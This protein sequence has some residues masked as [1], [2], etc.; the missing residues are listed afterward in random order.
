MNH[1]TTYTRLFWVFLFVLGNL[2]V[3]S[4]LGNYG[5]IQAAHL[6]GNG[7][8]PALESFWLSGDQDLVLSDTLPGAPDPR[9]IYFNNAQA[10]TLTLTFEISGTAP[11]TLSAGAVFGYTPTLRITDTV[12]ALTWQ[13]VITYSVPA[14][15]T[16]ETGVHYTITN[17]NALTTTLWL[18]YIQDIAPPTVTLNLPSVLTTAHQP[19]FALTGEAGDTGVG[20][21]QIEVQTEDAG[22]WDV[23]QGTPTWL[24]TWTLPNAD[25]FAYTPTARA[26]DHLGNQRRV[27]QTVIVDT[28]V[29]TVT[30]PIPHR[31]PWTTQTVIYHWDAAQDGAGIAGYRVNITNTQGYTDGFAVV[32]DTTTLTFTNA[33]MEGA[34]YYARVQAIDNH[35]NVGAWSET[36]SSVQP[37]LS[38]PIISNPSIYAPSEYFYVSGLTLFYTNTMPAADIFT[39]K[40]N[41]TDAPSGLDKATFSAALGQTPPMDASPSAFAGNYDVSPGDTDSGVI[42]ATLYDQAGQTSVQIFTYTLDSDPPASVAVAPSAAG[43]TPIHVTWNAIDT[44]SGVYSTTL[45]YKK[46]T[47]TAWTAY[48][49]QLTD[50]GT[51][52]FTPPAGDGTYYFS[53]VAT[54]HLGN[55]EGGRTISEAQT[56]FDTSAPQAKVSSVPDYAN[57][58]PIAVS[59]IA[60]PT[61]STLKEVRLWYRYDGGDWISTTLT[62]KEETGTFQFVGTEDGGYDFA[63]VAIDK[64]ERS[65]GEPSGDDGVEGTTFYDTVAPTVTVVVP[66]QAART[67]ISVAWEADDPAPASGVLSYQVAYQEDGGEWKTWYE[68]TTLTTANFISVATTLGHT[69][70]FSVTAQDAAGNAGEGQGTVRYEKFQVFIPL[71]SRN[72]AA[73]YQRDLNEP[74]DTR[75]QAEAQ[76][77]L[78]YGT[79]EAYIWQED[80]NDYYV[81]QP[82]D[83]GRI[84]VQLDYIPSGADYDLYIYD[85][86]TGSDYVTRSANYGNASEE[87]E[88]DATNGTKYYIRVY[89]YQGYNNDVL[90]KLTIHDDSN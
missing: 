23:A 57:T 36:G 77:N 71:T 19:D 3:L 38:P 88:F 66:T 83:S 16:T 84:R 13:P 25:H 65:D 89:P 40:G 44:L 30:A 76:D 34:E 20:V 85:K 1:K 69:Y 28:V 35:N 63:V 26:T 43:D 33:L 10:G 55:L 22:H 8:D 72:W 29:P 21:A 68:N 56:V 49:T 54:D 41:A 67:P 64:N 6:Q 62:S 12:G 52:S 59:W 53:T 27:S 7:G 48:G 81:F 80:D 46:A 87:V 74:N 78:S 58:S 50:T 86:P 73:W 11:L 45:W 14:T 90:Y 5:N 75:A 61:T 9:P 24:Y 15:A 42:T 79:Y 31:S 32:G 37:D 18:T 39:V 51:F 4:V 47:A 82:Q 60:T 70:T 2:I 17:A